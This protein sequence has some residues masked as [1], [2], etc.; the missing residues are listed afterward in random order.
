M[1][2]G[3][4]VAVIIPC[5]KVKAHILSV[6]MGIP[7]YVDHII[8]V[9][10]ACTEASGKYA[11][12]NFKD[13]LIVLFQNTNTG[14]GGAVLRGYQEAFR[15]GCHCFVKIDGDGQM[16]PEIMSK[17]IHPIMEGQ[18]DY[19]KGNRFFWP[20]GLESMPFVRKIGNAGLSFLT[21]LSTGYWDLMDPTNGYTALSKEAYSHLEKDKVAQRYFFE[22]DMLFRLGIIRAVVLDVPMVAVYGDEISGLKVGSSLISFFINHIKRVFKRIIYLYFVR[23]FNQGSLS[24]MFAI[25]F[26]IFGI[27]F[28]SYKWFQAYSTLTPTPVGTILLAVLPFSIGFQLLLNFLNYDVNNTPSRVLLTRV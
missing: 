23:D 21:K 2:N 7:E 8:V 4:K 12:E 3:K 11:E 14:V 26:L 9:D 25:P 15:L 10:D 19:T 17:F 18:A 24:L 28:G 1:I 5:Y 13:R 27:S 22:S 20:E 16:H 6:L